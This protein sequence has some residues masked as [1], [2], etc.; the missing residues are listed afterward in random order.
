MGNL[1][2][3]LETVHEEK[4]PFKWDICEYM[5]VPKNV[6]CVILRIESVHKKNKH[7]KCQICYV[8]TKAFTEMI[9]LTGIFKVVVFPSIF[10]ILS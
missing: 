10:E 2:R 3:Y 4:K 8:S 9:C 5:F 1:K 6:K 7:F